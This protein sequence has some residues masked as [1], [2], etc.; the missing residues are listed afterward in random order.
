MIFLSAQPDTLYF[1]WQ[2]EIQLLNFSKHGIPR[3][4]I[5][6]LAAYH[7]QKG[8]NYQ[9]RQF[10]IEYDEFASFFTYP[11][12]R[13][14]KDYL[15]SIRPHIIKQHFQLYE[16]LEKETIFYHDSDIVFT[17]QLPDFKRLNADDYWYF[18]DTRSYLDSNFIRQK[19]DLVFQEM[20][21]VAG[22][23]PELI[24][25]N[26]AN[27]GG[28]QALLK[29]IDYIFWAKIEKDCEKIYNL[30]EHNIE[31]YT[32]N[33]VKIKNTNKED[34]LPVPS[35][36]ADMWALLWNSFQLARVR[37]DT[38]MNFCWPHYPASSWQEN[39][40]FHNAGIDRKDSGQYF[41]KGLYN[42]RVPYGEDFSFVAE[43]TCDHYY[44]KLLQEA[45][46]KKYDFNDVTFA[47]VFRADTK[48]SIQNIVT[49]IKYLTK[50]FNTN[51]IVL[52]ADRKA[53]LKNHPVLKE[54]NVA[55]Y[56]I[57]DD[58]PLFCKN[59]YYNII[60]KMM[61][62][63]IIAKYD[64]DVIVPA[65][66]LNLSV[67]AIRYAEYHVSYPYDG[68]IVSTTGVLRSAF[69]ESFDTSLF[70]KYLTLP[71]T[72]S[73]FFAGCVLFNRNTYIK[74]GMENENLNGTGREAKEIYERSKIMGYRVERQ[75]GLLFVLGTEENLTSSS[76][77][78]RELLKSYTEY[79]RI[80]SMEKKE[81]STYIQSGFCQ[82][83]HAH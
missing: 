5:H 71:E 79:L 13:I 63:N 18:S 31:R 23:D 16:N 82:K 24:I 25:K 60:A 28:A 67:L 20:C 72:P 57:D 35:W 55:Y 30:L 51:I 14:H 12:N 49:V 3:D 53:N 77:G 65:P 27:A 68:R 26:D 39:K 4:E 56:Y 69:A 11:D 73:S 54:C 19:G 80:C 1:I 81:L 29:N 45:G 32:E 44:L 47:I 17:A 2:L 43:N 61:T 59:K 41:F 46:R 34:Y 75:E 8:L 78:D 62:T 66:Q 48:D 9:F 37:I 36:C 64:P 83:Q 22:V 33:Y 38:D 42:Q 50:N 76:V 10:M 7:P 15:S 40:I 70:Y 52:E 74:I 58:N 6:I 21:A